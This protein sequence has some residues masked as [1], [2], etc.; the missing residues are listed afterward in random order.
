ML[1]LAH[2]RQAGV[3][4]AMIESKVAR[5]GHYSAA[6]TGSGCARGG[7][8]APEAFASAVELPD[9]P[10][11]LG[12]KRALLE[13]VSG[14]S[15]HR[16]GAAPRLLALRGLRLVLNCRLHH[17]IH[18]RLLGID[19]ALYTFPSHVSE[20]HEGERPQQI[21]RLAGGL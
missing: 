13:L 3:T 6:R 20:R 8:P 19:V 2:D 21:Y 10:I 16:L 18:Q 4:V 5:E 1:A 7:E 15:R 14:N 11:R 12:C 17:G 9:V